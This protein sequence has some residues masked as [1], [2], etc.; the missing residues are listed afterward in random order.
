[1]EPFQR[2]I[3]DEKK[4]RLPT[5]H[6]YTGA[7]SLGCGLTNST[8]GWPLAEA[9]ARG[10]GIFDD[11]WAGERFAH[12]APSGELFEHGLRRLLTT[13]YDA[14]IHEVTASRA[15]K[16][17]GSAVVAGRSSSAGFR[18]RELEWRRLNSAL[19]RQYENEWV[20]LDGEEIVSHNANAAEAIRQAKSRGIRTPYIFFVEPESNDVVRIGL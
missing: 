9:E 5:I 7:G 11:T 12:G 20:V 3:E 2:A 13:N 15:E 14:L 16:K 18:Q 17:R 10:R 1:M 8:Y 19:L 4:A 6:V